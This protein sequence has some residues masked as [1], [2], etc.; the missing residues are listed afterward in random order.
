MHIGEP[1][2][3]GGELSSYFAQNIAGLK[4]F[5]DEF[6][7]QSPGEK[8]EEKLIAEI[9]VQAAIEPLSIDFDSV[10]KDVQS[11]RVSVRDFGRDIEI[12]GVRATR[13]FPFSG[14]GGLFQLRPNRWSSVLPYGIVSRHRI[15]IGLEDRNDPA[16]LKSYLD[17]Q[18]N[19]LHEY[20]SWQHENI[21]E[22][23]RSLPLKIEALVEARLKHLRG[24]EHLKD[25]I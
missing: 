6:I 2:F 18:Q 3:I 4:P 24:V 23:N 16:T 25:L 10:T 20:V 12:D 19:M 13:T 11:A 21:E 8:D 15:T 17:G 14:D 7:A 5:I 1:L 9:A 22:H